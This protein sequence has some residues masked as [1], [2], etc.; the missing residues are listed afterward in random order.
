V[1]TGFQDEAI[2]RG[3]FIR[4]SLDLRRYCSGIVTVTDIYARLNFEIVTAAVVWL[5]TASD[6]R[7]KDQGSSF[8]DPD[9]SLKISGSLNISLQ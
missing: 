1:S 3:L 7:V 8:N 2:L 6:I 9:L 5:L 4:S